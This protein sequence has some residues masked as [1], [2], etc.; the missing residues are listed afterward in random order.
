MALEGHS[1]EQIID[2]LRAAEV[3]IANACAFDR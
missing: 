1:A 2:K 3:E